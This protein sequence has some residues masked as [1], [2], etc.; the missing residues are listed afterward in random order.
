MNQEEL[1]RLLRIL[2]LHTPAD[3]KEAADVK[4]I[5]QM[6][7]S[8]PAIF[9]RTT[10]PGHITGSALVA[11]PSTGRYLLH[12]HKSLSR[13]LQF[14]GHSE[15]ETNPADIA[16]RE[17]AEES[18]LTDLAHFPP[19]LP[20]RPVDIDVH[21]IPA[22][23]GQPDHLHLDFRYLLTTSLPESL[24]AAEGESDTFRWLN[25]TEIKGLGE[26]IDPGLLRLIQK[27]DKL[28]HALWR[29]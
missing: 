21:A 17:A 20:V 5:Q 12:Y 26:Q 25:L 15:D 8:S 2:K 7:L 3:P 23:K 9:D 13:W 27:S 29:N 22:R 4:L 24:S 19:G 28:I 6:A 10:Y 11:D 1:E 16:M 18:G 14:G